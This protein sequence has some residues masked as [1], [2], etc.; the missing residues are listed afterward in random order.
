MNE[1]LDAMDFREI[2][3]AAEEGKSREPCQV[4]NPAIGE[5]IVRELEYRGYTVVRL[6]SDRAAK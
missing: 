4:G 3:A 6:P 5:R 2:A 1:S